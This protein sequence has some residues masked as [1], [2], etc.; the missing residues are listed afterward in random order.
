MAKD[1][2]KVQSILAKRRDKIAV[3]VK[4]SLS[5]LKK[6]GIDAEVIVKDEDKDTAFIVI[7]IEDIRKLIENKCR[8][9]VEKGAK[10]VEV[11]TY[12]EGDLLVIRVRK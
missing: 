2:R 11:V 7:P 4:N 8:Q 9:A 1:K 3:A 6:M 5:N 10:G 12:R